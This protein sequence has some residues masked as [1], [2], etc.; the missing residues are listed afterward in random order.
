MNIRES[1]RS[2]S[3]Y[4]I[5]QNTIDLACLRYGLSP[6]TEA[7]ADI[8]ISVDYVKA[9]IHVLQYLLSAPSNL[10]S[11]DSS[12]SLSDTDKQ[13]IAREIK[14]LKGHL[15]SLNHVNSPIMAGF[16]ANNL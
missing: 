4:P 13:A 2:L 3:N 1:L 5:P 12:V 8:I 6:E 9:Q 11:M 14:R 15:D 16:Y 10:G 7:T